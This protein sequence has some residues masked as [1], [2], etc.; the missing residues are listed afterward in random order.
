[1]HLKLSAV[2]WHRN[3]EFLKQL[4]SGITWYIEI[5]FHIYIIMECILLLVFLSS[6]EKSKLMLM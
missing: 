4:S 2:M 6:I 5:N 3:L 1:M